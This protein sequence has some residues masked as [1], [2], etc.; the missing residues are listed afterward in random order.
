MACSPY[1]AL[2]M[3]KFSIYEF[4][5]FGAAGKIESLS[6]FDSAAVFDDWHSCFPLADALYKA[7]ADYAVTRR[8]GTEIFEIHY[9]AYSNAAPVI[10][11]WQDWCRPLAR[12]ARHKLGLRSEFRV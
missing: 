3:V 12:F 11:A 7:R 10:R 5:V 1:G 9:C 2:I 8:N 6:H 4:Y